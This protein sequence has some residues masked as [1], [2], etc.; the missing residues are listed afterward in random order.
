MQFEALNTGDAEPLD[1]QMRISLLEAVNAGL[2]EENTR[3]REAQEVNSFIFQEHMLSQQSSKSKFCIHLGFRLYIVRN[4][5]G[6][7]PD[8]CLPQRTS[9]I[10]PPFIMVTVSIGIYF[11]TLHF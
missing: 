3:Y 6:I 2:L 1:L 8:T 9:I 11:L 7:F 4:T 10:D 5:F